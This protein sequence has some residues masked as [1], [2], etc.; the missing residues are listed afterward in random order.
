MVKMYIKKFTVK[1]SVQYGFRIFDIKSCILPPGSGFGFRSYVTFKEIKNKNK[2][3]I[4][5][6]KEKNALGSKRLHSAFLRI[7]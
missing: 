1:V 2:I 6:D 5:K 3:F 4:E 7:S